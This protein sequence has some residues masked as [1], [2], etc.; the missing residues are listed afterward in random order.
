MKFFAI[1]KDSLRE[2]IDCKALYV[3]MG[4]SAVAILVVASMSFKPVSAEK[5]MGALVSGDTMRTLGQFR[6]KPVF[7]AM[8]DFFP[9]SPFHLESVQALRGELDSPDSDYT[10]TV[11]MKIEGKDKAAK[12]REQPDAAVADLTKQFA[13]AE[14]L[15]LLQ[16]T[17]VRPIPAP[18]AAPGDDKVYFEVRTQPTHATRRLWHSELSLF[19]GALP[20][21]GEMALGLQLFTISSVVL[22]FGAWVAILVGVIITAFFIPNMLRKG[23]VD[24]M[25]VKPIQRWAIL[26]FKY[27]GGLTFIFLN[28]AFA[29]VGIWLALGLRSGVWA[30]SFL[31]MIF[32]ITFFFA[33]LYAVSTLVSVLTRSAVVA[34]LVTCAAWFLFYI[35]GT[36]FLVFDMQH[37]YEEQKE[38]PAD[39][40]WGDSAFATVVK[41]V[42][43]V[44]P[45]TSDLNQLSNRILLNDF[46]TGDIRNTV[47]AG[48]SS[49]SWGE[50]L[51]VSGVFVVLMLGLSCWWFATK[52]Y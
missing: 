42:H 24:L 1:L 30:N 9:Q 36:I 52:D 39:K 49:I 11:S 5:M 37:H 47:A 45:R 38:V 32:V 25:L 22:G 18:K 19:F 13:P 10:L 35:V 8:H 29:V 51:T 41:V 40:R 6:A 46:L 2:A 50:S 34:I 15:E 33:I 44:T 4:L 43:L 28:T 14:H 16:V 7:E 20:L 26:L 48:Q 23:T 31:L 17:E 12:T 21:P 3:L 27:L